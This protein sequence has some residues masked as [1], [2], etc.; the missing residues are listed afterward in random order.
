MKRSLTLFAIACIF[1]KPYNVFLRHIPGLL[2]TLF[3]TFHFAV[4]AA[5][6]LQIAD[7][8]KKINFRNILQDQDLAI[9]EVE[10]IVQDY[11]GFMWLGGRNALLRYDGVEF[12]SIKAVDPDDSTQHEPVTQIVELFE[13]SHHNLWVATRSGLYKY[14]QALELMLPLKNTA[15]A[16]I[17][18][19]L[20]SALAESP[21]GEL[22]IGGRNGVHF[23]NTETLSVRNL[24]SQP[25]IPKSL[26]S[27]IVEDLFMDKNDILWVGLAE[28]VVRLNLATMQTT[29]FELD[30]SNSKSITNYSIRTIAVDHKGL[31]W[32][33]SD[34]GIY[35]LNPDTGEVNIYRHDPKDPYSLSDNITRHIFVDRNGWVWSA[36]DAGGLCLYDEAHNHFLVFNNPP[37]EPG[38]LNSNT[39]RRIYEDRIGDLWVGAYPSGLNIFDRS[40]TSIRKYALSADPKRGLQGEYVEAIEENKDGTLWIGANGMSLFDPVTET[41]KHYTQTYGADSRS[42]SMSFLNG[43]VD[44]DGDVR[45][46]SWAHGVLRYNPEKDRFDELPA[47]GTLTKRGEKTSTLLNDKM[48]WS[49]YEDRQKTLWMATHYNGLTKFDKKTG[50]YTFYPHDPKKPDSISAA[51]VWTT[52]EDSSGRFW[53]GTAHG[54][55]LMDREKAT[56]KW[57][58]PTAGQ[59]RS[60]T[61]NSVLSIF[62]DKQKRLWVGTDGGLHLYH[63]ETDDFTVYTVKNG[64][65]DHGIRVI[66][67][68]QSGNL[69][70]GTNNGIVMFNPDTKTVR[71]YLR[72]N[73]NLIGGVST[74]AGI[75][76][77]SGEIAFGTRTGLYIIDANKLQLNENAPPVVLTDFR[78]FTEKVPVN[79]PKKILT[80]AINETKQITLDHTQSML[81]FNFAALNFRD[82]EKNQYAYQLQGFDEKWREVGNQHTALYTNLPPGTFTFRVMASN[83]DGI[84]N[85][86]GRSLILKILP[87]P[88]R[89]WTAYCIYA[90][91]L[92]GL[93][94]LILQRQRRKALIQ[95]QINHDLEVKV[96][97]RT[98][99]LQGAYAQLEAISLSDPLTG[100]SNRRY[101]QKVLP[102]D[103]AKVQREY[104]SKFSTKPVKKTPLDITFF[105]LDVDHFKSVNDT[106]GHATGDQLLIQLS[107]LL[108]KN[109]REFDFVVRWGGEEFLIVSRFN[110]RNEAPVIAERIRKNIEQHNFNLNGNICLKK[111]CSIGFAC[112]PFLTD[113]PTALSWEQV[114]DIADRALYAAKRSGRN[115]SVGLAAN[116][117]TRE[118]QLYQRICDD[119]NQLIESEELS[120]ISGS[121]EKLF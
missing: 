113:S 72:H 55:N 16:P 23:F 9:G 28:G 91:C 82:P 22:L 104:D 53:V 77:R 120:F 108:T 107:A 57:Y 34:S 88:W 30:P 64:F 40:S 36:S 94:W 114:I 115:R 5:E 103:V 80:K 63:P 6:T 93:V 46:A 25:G 112:F 47:D 42:D 45:F 92:L 15:G 67:E 3:F 17:F 61:N 102:L 78:I 90:A 96:A 48:V 33:G 12:V 52:F 100:L 83:N 21:Q 32:A 111:T 58:I 18:R 35:R 95:L 51:L 41:F 54:L 70:L 59:P 38:S 106:H 79:G 7:Y 1:G 117:D 76:T 121:S 39:L 24:G 89:T 74:G 109:C 85:K 86:E 62:E 56:F 66:V 44:S 87:P 75:V 31:V 65:S 81:S 84:W 37:G 101:L 49:V 110:D 60:L 13:D 99:E 105:I 26:P 10:A 2:F 68:D 119:L 69:W 27:D 116:S 98:A 29:L 43:V 8:P 73:G 97:E 20:V 4:S 50:L 11:Q 14:D 71:N 118:D 19:E